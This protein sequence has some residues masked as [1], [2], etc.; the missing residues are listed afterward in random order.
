MRLGE[1]NG[2]LDYAVKAQETLET[3]AGVVEH[4]GLYAASYGLALQRMVREPVQVCVIGD[5]AMRGGWRRW[6][7]AVCGEQE[8]GAIRESEGRG[9]AA[10]AGDD[11]A[12]PAEGRRELRGGVQRAYLPAAGDLAGGIGGSGRKN[13]VDEATPVPEPRP[14][15]GAS[16]ILR[17]AVDLS[18]QSDAGTSY[19]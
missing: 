9:V 13:S 15:A 7:C 12:A 10:G 8:R 11:A 1:L 2:R 5:D 14:R 6:R 3:F 18:G 16:C 4:F 19:T 17:A